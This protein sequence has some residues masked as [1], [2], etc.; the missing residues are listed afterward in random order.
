[1]A[2]LAL[3]VKAFGKDG[4]RLLYSGGG[5]G[6]VIEVRPAAAAVNNE[7][8]G[9]HDPATTTPWATY[10]N[11]L[12][13]EGVVVVKGGA[14]AVSVAASAAVGLSG[15]PRSATWR[16]RRGQETSDVVQLEAAK[17][18]AG[19][20]SSTA[21][22]LPLDDAERAFNVLQWF[23]TVVVDCRPRASHRLRESVLCADASA[24]LLL[25]P[26]DDAVA[27][28]APPEILNALAT[29]ARRGVHVLSERAL[30]ALCTQ[31]PSLAVSCIV[32]ESREA[33]AAAGAT[34][35]GTHA[36]TAS[37]S[38][39]G[40]GAFS[41]S[42]SAAAAERR[43]VLP[44]LADGKLLVGHQGH[45]M[46]IRDWEHH[47]H[48]GGVIN[49]APKHVD[50]QPARDAAIAA[51]AA[52]RGT[53]GTGNDPA[54]RVLELTCADG[55]PLT[56]KP[57]DGDRLLEALPAALEFIAD[58]T[59]EGRL[60]FIHCQQGRSRAGSIATAYLLST[61]ASWTLF[62]SVAFLA[63][64]RPETEIYEEYARALEQ[65]AV[66]LL[67]REPS[68]SR[69][70]AEL[71]RQIR[72]LPRRA[73]KDGG[74]LAPAGS[75]PLAPAAMVPKSEDPG[76]AVDAAAAAQH[77]NLPKGS[78]CARGS[79]GAAA[80]RRASTPPPRILS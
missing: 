19:A 51:A 46:C 11:A 35:D 9:N 55:L 77:A 58:G 69:V 23:G 71:P 14:A 22:V 28:G 12:E 24:V 5:D 20:T 18:P 63:A 50:A 41:A 42:A 47:V 2:D 34:S 6:T 43:P 16:L 62:D 26:K 33:G 54:W 17:A 57:G 8:D 73:S 10:T 65:W 7:N 40:D 52:G 1:M 45:A 27:I 48:L 44:N 61:H 59:T 66:E 68:L 75:V 60:V 4:V 15:P 30:Q 3:R 70:L 53:G 37:H 80:I 21:A 76:N 25:P 29:R 38:S 74:S 32:A 79:F 39:S 56:D 36:A 49:L 78:P 72:P 31:H 64:R 13:S 67:G